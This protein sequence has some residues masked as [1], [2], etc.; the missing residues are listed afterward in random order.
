M[1][2]LATAPIEYKVVSFEADTDAPE[3]SQQL[4]TLGREGWNVSSTY[5]LHHLNAVF[6]VLM[7]AGSTE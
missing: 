2:A 3:L 5:H 7:R 4:T 1:S 6:F